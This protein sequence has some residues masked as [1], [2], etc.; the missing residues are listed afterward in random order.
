M[1]IWKFTDGSGNDDLD[2]RRMCSDMEM[3]IWLTDGC[4]DMDLV[5]IW[6]DD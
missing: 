4:A 2:H 5:L 6:L 1:L 3:M